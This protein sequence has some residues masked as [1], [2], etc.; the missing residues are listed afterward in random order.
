MSSSAFTLTQSGAN[1]LFCPEGTIYDSTNQT[2]SAT[3]PLTTLAQ[4]AAAQQV[5][6]AT[7]TSGAKNLVGRHLKHNNDVLKMGT[8]SFDSN[9][10]TPPWVNMPDGGFPFS[11]NGTINTPAIGSG[12][13]DVIGPAGQYVMQVPNGSDG[14]IKTLVCFY[15]G[16]G[17]VSGSGALIWRILIDGQAARNYDNILVQLGVTPFPG[18]TEGIRIKSNQSIQ[19]QVSNVS[20]IGAG[21]QIFC[22]FGGWYYPSKLS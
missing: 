17:F 11:A 16:G 21:T 12:F 18:N 22:F 4:I 5:V 20:Q 14:V 2:C 1:E 9:P 19:F 7:A 8:H 10:I 6:A 15:N 3:Q 13:V